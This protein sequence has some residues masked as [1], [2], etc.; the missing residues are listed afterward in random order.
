MNVFLYCGRMG[1]LPLCFLVAV[2]H[3]VLEQQA[4]VSDASGHTSTSGV[5]RCVSAGGQSG[6][7][8]YSESGG[9][10]HYGGFA[11]ACILLPALDLDADG[12]ANELD[13]DNDGDTLAD[14]LEL[15]GEPWWPA[16]VVSNPNDPDTDNDG[17]T[18]GDEALTGTNPTNALSG[19]WIVDIQPAAFTNLVVT[20]QARHGKT[21]SLMHYSSLS[22]SVETSLVNTVTVNDPSA[23]VPWYETYATEADRG[24]LAGSATSGF[25]RVILEP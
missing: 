9:I 21:Y 25:Y 3:A 13:G 4:G 12:V 17:F 1:V 19:L 11:G 24:V 15:S 23:V 7:F 22:G 18:D 16:D 10:R 5:M 20:W 2:C 6:G 8:Q 14:A